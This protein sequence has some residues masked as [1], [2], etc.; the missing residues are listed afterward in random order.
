MKTRTRRVEIL[1]L[2]RPWF[3]FLSNTYTT[4]LIK[5]GGDDEYQG[6]TTL[7]FVKPDGSGEL[8]QQCEFSSRTTRLGSRR[9]LTR[10]FP[11]SFPFTLLAHMD[12]LQDVP[13]GL[14]KLLNYLYDRYKTPIY[15]T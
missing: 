8:G 4:N 14:R 6:C 3:L 9:S 10:S 2:T 5:A 12:W 7:T 1:S 11:S 13:W 15:M